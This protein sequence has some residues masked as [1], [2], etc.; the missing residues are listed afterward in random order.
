MEAPQLHDTGI[1][2]TRRK[3]HARRRGTLHQPGGDGRSDDD[4]K[5][6]LPRKQR[7][8]DFYRARGVTESMSGDIENNYSPRHPLVGR[9]KRAGS[10]ARSIGAAGG[11]SASS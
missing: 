4:A 6:E 9:V 11:C 3:F 5:I 1:D 2:F 8:D 10:F 7:V